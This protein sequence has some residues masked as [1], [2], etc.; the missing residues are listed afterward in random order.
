M[1]NIWGCS[2]RIYPLHKLTRCVED[3][4]LEAMSPSEL[5]PGWYTRTDFFVVGIRMRVRV[6]RFSAQR[7][8]LAQRVSAAHVKA[9]ASNGEQPKVHNSSK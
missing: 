1:H 4:L 8:R 7:P 9:L 2:T 3:T 5:A 6:L